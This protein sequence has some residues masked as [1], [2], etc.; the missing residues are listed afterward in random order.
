MREVAEDPEARCE[1]A[2]QRRGVVAKVVGERIDLRADVALDELI[3]RT[4]AE[5][6]VRAQLMSDAQLTDARFEV[7]PG[8][9]LTVALSPGIGRILRHE[10]ECGAVVRATVRKP[11]RKAAL[12]EV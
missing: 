5:R 9:G 12:L 11:T 6:P 8:V 2:G 3:E 1:A 10:H 4:H 7:D